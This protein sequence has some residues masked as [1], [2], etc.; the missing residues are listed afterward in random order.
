VHLSTSLVRSDLQPGAGILG[1]NNYK[2]TRP[3]AILRRKALSCVCV[4]SWLVPDELEQVQEN[5]KQIQIIDHGTATS[6]LKLARLASNPASQRWDA[7]LSGTIY[8]KTNHSTILFIAEELV[9][10]A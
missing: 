7:A 3:E 1:S 4:S 2:N 8:P 5:A 10:R 9:F 6:G